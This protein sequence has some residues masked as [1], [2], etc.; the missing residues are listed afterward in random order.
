MRLLIILLMTLLF[1]AS[2]KYTLAQAHANNDE[3]QSHDDAHAE[4]H[5]HEHADP[6]SDAGHAD[7]HQA[8]D[9]MVAITPVAARDSGI[10]EAIAEH[11]IIRT[12]RRLYG[13]VVLPSPQV[14]HVRAR[15]PGVV[16]NVQVDVGDRVDAGDRLA[17]VEADESLVTYTIDAPIAG[18]VTARH[19]N[20]GE[21]AREQRLFSIVDGR[22]LRAELRLFEDQRNLI[23]LGQA[24][25]LQSGSRIARGT[26]DA[27]VPSD[28]GAP[29][30]LAIVAF[31]N[32][33]AAWQPGDFVAALV[34]TAS[35][36]VAVRVD[37]E[38]IQQLDGE[39]VIFARE[40]DAYVARHVR[41]GQSDDHHTEVLEGL[42]AGETYAAV[43]SFVVKSELGKADASHD[44]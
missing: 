13:P 30:A 17:S 23:R 5:A 14:S 33:S 28:D 34:E 16:T 22:R 9:E 32:E 42:S 27:I 40:A 4:T 1:G 37:N 2:G 35:T 39:A 26:I 18:I 36:D 44:H 31:A 11:G 29:F 15:Y 20:A 12:S 8:G 24:V 7:E 43:G 38:A 6:A 3:A 10:Q 21:L 41:L 25:E 19:A